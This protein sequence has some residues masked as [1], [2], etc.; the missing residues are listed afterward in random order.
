MLIAA[1]LISF[2]PRFRSRSL[3]LPRHS[4]G[5]SDIQEVDVRILDEEAICVRVVEVD[6]VDAL[7]GSYSIRKTN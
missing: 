1:V 6:H 2:N 4:V 5:V 7:E 3:L